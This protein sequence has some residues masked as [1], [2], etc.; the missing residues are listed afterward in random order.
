WLSDAWGGARNLAGSAWRGVCAGGEFVD[1]PEGKKLLTHE[2]IHVVQQ[3]GPRSSA[4]NTIARSQI[5]LQEAPATPAAKIKRIIVDG[6]DNAIEKLT[7]DEMAAATPAQRAG[8]IRILTDLT[9]TNVSE[10]RATVRLLKAG[11]QSAQVLAHL[12]SLGYRQKV[13][14]SVDNAE[15]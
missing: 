15:L 4:G 10:E 13:I 1:N 14:D 5:Q 7:D 8:M 11:G 9:W 3:Q 6:D 2:L 12:D